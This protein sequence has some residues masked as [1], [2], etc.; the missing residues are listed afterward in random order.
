MNG[1]QLAALLSLTVLLGT[2]SMVMNDLWGRSKRADRHQVLLSLRASAEHEHQRNAAMHFV[3]DA[4]QGARSTL[5]VYVFS[6]T[7]PQYR[8]NLE[9]FI[10]Q[11]I[12]EDD[13]AEYYIIVQ[14]AAGAQ[15]L[16][17]LPAHAHYVKH[18][19]ECY[20]WWAAAHPVVV[21][22]TTAAAGRQP[23]PVG[24]PPS[25]ADL[26]RAGA[27]TGGCCW[28]AASSTTAATSS[29]YSSTAP[30]GGPTSRP[31]QPGASPGRAPSSACCPA[32]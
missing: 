19:N 12:L 4:G 22:P 21:P 14:D 15:D 24:V 13:S 17:A 11:G 31:M 26:A 30:S 18:R 20:D 32:A 27:R 2:A 6:D 7:D 16:P 1:L 5:C 29:S 25:A 23:P 3:G 8:G 10:Q 28:R 9:A